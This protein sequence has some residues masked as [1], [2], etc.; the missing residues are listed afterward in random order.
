MFVLLSVQYARVTVGPVARR[1]GE[2]CHENHDKRVVP[3]WNRPHLS[4]QVDKGDSGDGSTLHLHQPVWKT[5][6][7]I[8]IAAREVSLAVRRATGPLS[9]Q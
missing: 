7:P 6:L 5:P 2:P 4:R 9:P 8:L 1:H 3:K